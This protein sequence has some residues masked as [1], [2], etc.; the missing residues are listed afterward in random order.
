MNES[1]NDKTF[2]Y[3]ELKSGDRIYKIIQEYIFPDLEKIGFKLSK[4][5]LAITRK[6]G[7]YEQTIYFSKNKNNYNNEV[8]AFFPQFQVTSKAYVKWCKDRY[9]VEP[10]NENIMI[11]SPD[12][13]TNW[14]HDYFFGGYYNFAKDDNVAIVKAI[15]E[16]IDKIG[17]PYLDTFC[18]NQSAINYILESNREFH[19]APMLFDFAVMLG[20]KLQAEKILKWHFDFKNKFTD[21]LREDTLRD[22]ANRQKALDNWK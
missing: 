19:L 4:S 11:S 17:L 3:P 10:I 2:L 21:S 15:K 16:N 5:P 14:N 7:E 20:D 1:S 18:D 9:G 22:V 6:V 13:I 8:V 12:Y